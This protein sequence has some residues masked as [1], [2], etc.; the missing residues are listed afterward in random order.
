MSKPTVL[1]KAR[2]AEK[3]YLW[4]NYNPDT[5]YD[6]VYVDPEATPGKGLIGVLIHDQP[7]SFRKQVAYYFEEKNILELVMNE[8]TVYLNH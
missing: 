6:V 2:V 5:F 1:G 7:G 3:R 4:D 8:P